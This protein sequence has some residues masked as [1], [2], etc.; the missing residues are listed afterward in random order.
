MLELYHNDMSVCA[1]KVRIVLA[2][3]NLDWEG[4]NVNLRAGEQ[5][6]PDFLKISP[7]GLVPILLH[8][9]QVVY[10]SNVIIEYLEEV[11]SDSP[12]LT[13]NPLE[14]A[15]TRIW[16]TRLDAGLHEQVAVLSFCIAFRHQMLERYPTDEA[17]QG[18]FNNIVDPSR[19][20]VMEDM[21]MNGMDS[22]RL[23]LA[24]LAYDKLIQDMGKVLALND[25]LVGD[26]IS[27]AD[28]AFVPYIERLQQLQLSAWW[29]EYPQLEQWLARMRDTQAYEI[30]VRE[31]HNPA[32]IGLMKASGAN[33][34]KQLSAVLKA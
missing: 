8:D 16:L 2:H 29:S 32:Y 18:F 24:V 14:R 10:E 31:W 22:P 33:A 4:P 1:Q 20:A 9:K 13:T 6:A 17:L 15:K 23:Y 28:M 12:L 27:L 19:R 25:W 21:V 30:G 11:F 5:F 26:K 3:K 34:W 7:K